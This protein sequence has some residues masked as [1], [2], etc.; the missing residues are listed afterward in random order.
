[1]FSNCAKCHTSGTNVLC[2][3]CSSGY[4]KVDRS[5]CVLRLITTIIIINSCSLGDSHKYLGIT[6]TYCVASCYADN[7]ATV[8][9]SS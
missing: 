1:M 3:E 4:L 9:D 2:S 6:L 7:S 5:D 8:I